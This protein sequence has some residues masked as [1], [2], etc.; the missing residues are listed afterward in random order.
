M[1][2]KL[3]D[4]IEA[5]TKIDKMIAYWLSK[6]PITRNNVNSWI[7]LVRSLE[8]TIVILRNAIVKEL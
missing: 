8:K 5:G 4:G 3:F 1:N 2:S 7:D 6:F